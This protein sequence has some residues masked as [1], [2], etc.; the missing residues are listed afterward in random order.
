[1]TIQIDQKR[2]HFYKEVSEFQ[3][4][5][6]INGEIIIHSPVAREHNIVSGNL[7]KI[8]DTY[9]VEKDLGFV[10]IEKIMIQL[11]RN[12]YE[13]D[14]C[15]FEKEV[16]EGFAKGQKIFPVPNMIVEILSK[17]TRSR[18][19]GVKFDD[20]AKHRVS[21]YWII[22]AEKETLEQYL[23]TD[24]SGEYELNQKLKTGIVESTVI[25][26]LSIPVPV[27]FDKRQTNRFLVEG[28]FG[29]S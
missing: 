17:G 28:L 18:D 24:R 6:F 4:S 1:M 2:A 5:E 9:V 21:E 8:L 25:Q 16:A 15:F 20:Y 11:T 14:L 29:A 13:P 23:L 26:G 19:R 22:D 12:D 10:G 27:L 3:K 7:Y